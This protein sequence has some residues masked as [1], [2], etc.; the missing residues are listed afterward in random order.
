MR[1]EGWNIA[2]RFC[3]HC[4]ARILPGMTRCA[5]CSTPLPAA[6]LAGGGSALEV[7]HAPA[8]S[9]AAPKAPSGGKDASGPDL[10]VCPPAPAPRQGNPDLPPCPDETAPPPQPPAGEQAHA[11]VLPDLPPAGIAAAPSDP[12][13]QSDSAP[14]QTVP[15]GMPLPGDAPAEAVPLPAARPAV[16]APP[17][18]D[19]PPQAGPQYPAAGEKEDGSLSTAACLSTLLLFLIPVAGLVVMLCYV[20][21]RG[22]PEGRRNLARACLLLT[23]LLLLLLVLVQLAVLAVGGIARQAMLYSWY[24]VY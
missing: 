1:Q 14:A 13:A 6:P 2:M 7:P 16:A 8:E 18:P 3:T 4:G 17:D 10:D 21:G 23:V 9:A 5:S 24:G 15:A 19:R 22:I 20:Y 12:A 11:G